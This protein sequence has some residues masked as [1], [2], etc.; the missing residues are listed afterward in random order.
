MVNDLIFFFVYLLIGFGCWWMRMLLFGVVVSVDGIIW[1]WFWKSFGEKLLVR[2]WRWEFE[3]VLIFIIV[4]VGFFFFIRYC[5]LF[6]ILYLCFIVLF[7][8]ENY[9]E[10]I[11]F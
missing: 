6:E 11:S 10:I 4:I 5:G 3:W 7:K 1:F 2:V 8:W 9:G